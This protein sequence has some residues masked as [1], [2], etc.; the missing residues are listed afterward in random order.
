[1]HPIKGR[2]NLSSDAVAKLKN[3]GWLPANYTAP[4]GGF[5]PP[6]VPLEPTSIEIIDPVKGPS[7]SSPKAPSNSAHRNTD[8]FVCP[9]AKLYLDWYIRV[10]KEPGNEDHI[11]KI[12]EH[13][14]EITV[15]SNPEYGVTL[16]GQRSQGASPQYLETRLSWDRKFDV[17]H[18]K[19]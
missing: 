1:P 7:K 15:T 18:D 2:Q 5:G 6:L 17:T 11:A 14:F 3:L 8:N 10:P 16:R 4:A 13:G 19:N 9:G 12:T